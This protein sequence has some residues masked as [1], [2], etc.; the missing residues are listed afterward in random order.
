VNN[1]PRVLGLTLPETLSWPI[2]TKFGVSCDT[3]TGCTKDY[4]R[5][6]LAKIA[7][8]LGGGGYFYN[9]RLAVIVLIIGGFKTAFQFMFW[10]S[11]GPVLACFVHN[12]WT[13]C[14]LVQN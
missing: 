6:L 12:F 10:I 8:R 7:N 3:L 14:L 9:R 5:R 13:F 2:D 1:I 4:N 11:F